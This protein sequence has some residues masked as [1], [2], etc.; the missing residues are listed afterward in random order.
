M[1]R[2]V[3]RDPRAVA[4]ASR[5]ELGSFLVDQRIEV[6]RS[7]TLGEL[8][9]LV[10]HEFGANPDAFVA[11][12]TVARFGPPERAAAA[13]VETRHE[14]RLLLKAARRGLTLRDRLRG[15]LSVRSLTRPVDATP[16]P[17]SEIA[18]GSTGS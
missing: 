5:Q 15:L 2:T 16:A 6:P 17:G 11:A 18:V 1:A 12:G 13:A 9:E 3:R 14:L 7:A 4:A 10:R 8:G